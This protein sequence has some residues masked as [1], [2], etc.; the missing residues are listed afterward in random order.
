MHR[1]KKVL[2]V[3]PARGGSKGIPK[4]NL[5]KINNKSLIELVSRFCAASK[6]FDEVVCSTDDAEIALEANRYGIKTPFTRSSYLSTDEIGDLPVLRNTI[7]EIENHESFEIVVLLQP[8]APV[9]FP[10]DLINGLDLLIEKQVQ[11]VWSVQEIDSKYH[12]KKIL[13]MRDNFL[14]LDNP[15]GSKIMARQQLSRIFI[16]TG[17]FY[18]F[19]KLSILKSKTWY[20][21]KTLPVIIE[22]AYP[23]IDTQHDLN[24]TEQ[25]F[26]K[27]K[28]Y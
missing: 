28:P 23:S 17:A 18:I 7:L 11:A 13:N 20:L 14:F 25:E 15:Q 4:K 10:M 19:D 3:V 6:V 22:R 26:T 2:G 21:K 9:R 5:K 1:N 27:V 24:L 12:P 16:R 8:T